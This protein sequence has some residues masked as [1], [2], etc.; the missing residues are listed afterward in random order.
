MVGVSEVTLDESKRNEQLV[1]CNSRSNV[2]V[3][4]DLVRVTVG[5]TEV[6]LD[7]LE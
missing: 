6:T 2:S 5:V 7:N 3:T 4:D 1:Q